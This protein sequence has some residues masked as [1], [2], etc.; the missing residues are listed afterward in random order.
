MVSLSGAIRVSICQ[1]KQAEVEQGGKTKPSEWGSLPHFR[2]RF[3]MLP[4]IFSL[5]IHHTFQKLRG[6]ASPW[7]RREHCSVRPQ[8][9]PPQN[10]SGTRMT[11]GKDSLPTPPA[12]EEK[13]VFPGCWFQMVTNESLKNFLLVPTSYQ[14]VGGRG[15][16]FWL[17][18]IF[19]S[20]FNISMQS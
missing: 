6:Q 9:F 3:K 5:Q 19:S 17:F 7:D 11:K 12:P 8:L 13:D 14:G 1:L 10:S 4:H 16:I 2:M 18:M 20:A 15:Y